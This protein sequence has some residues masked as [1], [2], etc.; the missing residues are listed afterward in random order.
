MIGHYKKMRS[1]ADRMEMI[2]SIKVS[3][4]NED[5]MFAITVDIYKSLLNFLLLAFSF[6]KE[7]I[8]RESVQV[9]HEREQ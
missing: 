7:L 1:K 2:C 4:E 8:E 3:L 9:Q 5:V 6:E